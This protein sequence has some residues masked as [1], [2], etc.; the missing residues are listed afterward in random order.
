MRSERRFPAGVT[1]LRRVASVGLGL[2]LAASTGTAQSVP[3]AKVD[4]SLRRIFGTGTRADSLHPDS[5]TVLRVARGDTLLGWAVIR[6]V[7]GK[8]QMITVL[9]AVDTT[10]RLRDVDILAYR[11][12]YGGEVAYEGWRK[13]FRGKDAGDP[14]Q[15]G[16][17]IRNISGATISTHAV[18]AGVR[19]T[20]ADFARWRGEGVFR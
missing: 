13:Q 10:G 15:V 1:T 4:A 14:L 2:L 11:E 17:D 9:V 18:T 3:A 5:T 20:L 7:K 6:N 8:D 12:P 16:R 19:R